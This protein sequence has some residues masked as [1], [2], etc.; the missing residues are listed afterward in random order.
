MYP[1]KTL[2]KDCAF[3]KKGTKKS[4]KG[5][6]CTITTV[7]TQMSTQMIGVPK[8]DPIVDGNIGHIN[9]I[10]KQPDIEACMFSALSVAGEAHRTARKH[11]EPSSDTR[12]I[13]VDTSLHLPLLSPRLPGE[14]HLIIR[15]R[16]V[17]G[18]HSW[19]STF[20]A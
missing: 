10:H 4:P 15:D 8:T 7:A 20:T 9:T 6:S 1:C 18:L 12:T 19:P 16:G 13:D 2:M 14:E 17:C 5:L 3:F 11:V